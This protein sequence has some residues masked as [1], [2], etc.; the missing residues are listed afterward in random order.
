LREVVFDDRA[1]LDIA[2]ITAY[3]AFVTQLA[4][5]LGSTGRLLEMK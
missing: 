2:R 1:I 4:D 5:G 3:S